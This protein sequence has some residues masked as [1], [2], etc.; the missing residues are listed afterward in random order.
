[1]TDENKLILKNMLAQT[2]PIISSFYNK[3]N[4]Q[5]LIFSFGDQ[6]H[7][8]ALFLLCPALA[9]FQ[10]PIHLIFMPDNFTDTLVYDALTKFC[11]F[12]KINLK[13]IPIKFLQGLYK[14]LFTEYL[15]ISALETNQGDKGQTT[16]QTLNA[17]RQ[18]IISTLIK[19]K[20]YLYLDTTT[21]THFLRGHPPL[22][23]AIK[24]TLCPFGQV[25]LSC[26]Y[27]W[28]KNDFPTQ[29]N[30]DIEKLSHLLSIIPGS[31]NRGDHQLIDKIDELNKY[32]ALNQLDYFPII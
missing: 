22:N 29:F 31:M 24:H 20:N 5:S 11:E 18:T 9:K 4:A 17:I 19:E 28:I 3:N 32:A 8:L 2:P 21:K 23:L 12:Y 13:I 7:D 10:I 1:M 6:L 16:N 26:V 25:G 30:E 15:H 27:D 14:N